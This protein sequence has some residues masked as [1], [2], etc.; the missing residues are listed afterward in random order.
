MPTTLIRPRLDD[1]KTVAD[2]SGFED[3]SPFGLQGLRRD[4]LKL[5]K[6]DCIGKLAFRLAMRGG[7]K[8]VQRDVLADEILQKHPEWMEEYEVVHLIEKSLWINGRSDLVMTLLK[9]PSQIPDSPPPEIKHALL[10]ANML[11]PTA[12]VWYG[13]P[14]FGDETTEDGLPVPLSAREVREENRRRIRAAQSRAMKYGWL[15][16]LA[17]RAVGLP[18]VLRR[19]TSELWRHTME[20][21]ERTRRHWRQ[22]R[23]DMRLRRRVRALQEMEYIRL[24]RACTQMP[25]HSTLLGR[26]ASRATDAA[27]IARQRMAVHGT[28]M[29]ASSITFAMAQVLPMLFMPMTMVAADP[30]LFVE[31]PDEPGMLRHVG[32]WYWQGPV[33]G[34]QKLHLHV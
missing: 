6:S 16:K 9:N 29:G 13:V 2:T 10:R 33:H 15:Y 1:R 26:V 11:H 3:S 22:I 18:F 25:E 12:T 24:G 34:D 28:L 5:L 19:L 17:L 30:F 20:E 21:V 31:L 27:E 7:R 32:H 4:G 14:L 8:E 23:R